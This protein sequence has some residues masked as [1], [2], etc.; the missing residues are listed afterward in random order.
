MEQIAAPL[1][2]HCNYHA[3]ITALLSLHCSRPTQFFS[4]SAADHTCY[5]TY[6]LLIPLG[7]HPS[8][9]SFVDALY[10]KAYHS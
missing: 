2:S 9:M 3:F 5:A 10:A 4:S 8:V 7:K 1:S 6:N